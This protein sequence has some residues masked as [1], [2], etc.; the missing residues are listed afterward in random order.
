MD[1]GSRAGL[2]AL[3]SD[4]RKR[5]GVAAGI[6]AYLYTA[7]APVVLPIGPKDRQVQLIRRSGQA[8]HARALAGDR[9]VAPPRLRAADGHR[10]GQA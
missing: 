1:S 2:K 3:Y 5:A 8:R 6:G 10:G 9:A 7:L 4:A